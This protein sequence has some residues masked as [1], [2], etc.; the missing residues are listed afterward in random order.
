MKS[1]G[2][3]SMEE[4]QTTHTAADNKH[5]GLLRSG[6]F[7]V[8]GCAQQGD[9]LAFWDITS[10][11]HCISPSTHHTNRHGQITDPVVPH[12]SRTGRMLCRPLNQLQVSL[13]APR[14]AGLWCRPKSAIGHGRHAAHRPESALAG[15]RDRSPTLR[16]DSAFEAP[17]PETACC[18]LRPARPLWEGRL[19]VCVFMSVL[20]RYSGCL[21]IA[22]MWSALLNAASQWDPDVAE[23]DLNDCS[24]CRT[25]RSLQ[26][27]VSWPLTFVGRQSTSL[28]SLCPLSSVPVCCR[29]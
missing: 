25:T 9:S 18:V 22:S 28:R 27:G 19:C 1:R 15:L 8:F 29:R 21:M 10:G 24:E 7:G 16:S 20:G 4:M 14:A 5:A 2:Q 17:P 13:C 12:V 6:I 26:H 11:R 23:S 3:D